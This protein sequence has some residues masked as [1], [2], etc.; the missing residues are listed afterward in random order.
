MNA[1][2]MARKEGWG[3]MISHRSGETC[4]TFIADLSVALATGQIKTGAPCR[5]E[6]VE[7]YNQILRINE[8]LGSVQYAGMGSFKIRGL[9]QYRQPGIRSACIV[10]DPFFRSF[11]C[12]HE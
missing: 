6:R 4:D 7:K 9:K 2:H 8:E 11:T 5:G 1:I 12:T 3:A 10:S